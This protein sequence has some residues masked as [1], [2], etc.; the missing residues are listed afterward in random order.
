MKF[1]MH[2]HTNEGSLDGKVGIEETIITLKSK[3]FQGMLVTDH[4]SYNGY[5]FWKDEIKEKRHKGFIVLKGIEYDTSNA[6]HMLVVMPSGIKPR[7]LEL[8]GM[9]L[10]FLIAVVHAYG[11]IIGPAHPCGEK[12]LS[13]TNTKAYKKHQDI[14]KKFD[15]IEIF[16]ACETPESNAQAKALAKEYFL[17]GFGGSDSH[18]TD[19]VGMAYSKFSD[20]ITSE[21]DLIAAVKRKAPIK[22]RGDYYHGTTKEKMGKM[23]GLL[24][25]SFWLYN[26]TAGLMKVRKRRG[27]SKYMKINKK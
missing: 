10:L 21:E 22:S 4:N 25:Y 13:F 5:R 19:C 24:V 12:Y 14:A 7:I 11:G 26:K 20:R 18:R 8:R 15:F 6:G 23:N 1:D 16:N 9:P 17:P 27:Q 3:G 2:C